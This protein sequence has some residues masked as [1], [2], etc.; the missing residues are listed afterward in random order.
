METDSNFTT[1]HLVDPE[2]LPLLEMFPD[3][4]FNN[5]NLP[6]IRNQFKEQMSAVP[7]PPENG[8]SVEERLIPG[9]SDGPEVRVIIYTPPHTA[10]MRPA[11]LHIHGGGYVV[12]EPG[13]SHAR[14]YDLSADLGCVVV[15]VDYRL[16]PEHPHPAPAEDCYAALKWLYG[17]ASEMGVNAAKIAIGGESAGGG[18]SAALALLARDRKEVPI[19]FQWL[20]YPMLD[21]RTCTRMPN[22]ATGEFIWTRDANHYG[23]K[24][25]LGHAPGAAG[26]SPYASAARTQSVA[27]LPPT[28]IGVGALDLFLDE[29]IAYAQ[30]L[31]QA[32]VPTEFHVYPGAYHGFDMF[33]GAVTVS[34][35]FERDMRDALRKALAQ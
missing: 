8:V 21:D 23:W 16:P 33:A 17:N 1:R 20:I 18:L 35:Q 34:K 26:V 31:M 3:Y 32:S 5:E 27:G 2:L 19:A 14:N 13:M 10:T 28:F 25:L 7:V 22:P 9:A 30:R 4:V 15:S 24:S 11:L 12:G 6:S 29:N